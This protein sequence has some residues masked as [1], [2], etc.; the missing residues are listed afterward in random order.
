MPSVTF[1]LPKSAKRYSA[2]RLQLFQKAYSTPPP[3]VT[4]IVFLARADAGRAEILRRRGRKR[5]QR[6]TDEG[7]VGVVAAGL[8]AG[9]RETAG[10]VDQQPVPRVAEAA[11][12]CRLPLALDR[13]GG[14]R[15]ARDVAG[16]QHAGREF[17]QLAAERVAIAHHLHVGF[18]AVHDVAGLEIVADLAAADERRA[19]LGLSERRRRRTR[20]GCRRKRSGSRRMRPVGS[21]KTKPGEVRLQLAE[22][23]AIQHARP[24]SRRYRRRPS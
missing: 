8:E 22:I 20:R 15:V 5:G 18:D 4:P 1:R 11:A 7:L 21:M 6:R 16:R 9:H 12:E 17:K 24:R 23:V 2:P 3:K 10:R 13:V 19:G 14:E